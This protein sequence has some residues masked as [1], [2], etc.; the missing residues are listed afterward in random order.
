V[1]PKAGLAV[2]TQNETITVS[3]SNGA[4]ATVDVKFEVKQYTGIDH[5]QA[6]TLKA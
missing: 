6:K 3:G 1:Q 5:A 2:G 4:T